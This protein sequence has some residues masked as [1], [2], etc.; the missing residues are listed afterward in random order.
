MICLSL[1]RDNA[2]GIVAFDFLT[3]FR[4]S[5]SNENSGWCFDRKAEPKARLSAGLIPIISTNLGIEGKIYEDM[6]VRP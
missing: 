4:L 2:D 5:I 6:F 3:L 1:Y